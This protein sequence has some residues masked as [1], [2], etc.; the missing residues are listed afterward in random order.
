MARAVRR[1]D[2]SATAV[3]ADH[4]DSITGHDRVIGA[5]R[6]VRPE[7][8]AEAEIVDDQPDLG[9]LSLA[10][11]PIAVKENTAVTG[12]PTWNGSHEA[13]QPVADSDHEVVRRLR[14]AGA[15]V[16]G[17]TRMPELGLFATTDDA[18][19]VTRNPWRTDCTA[20]GSSGGS[21]A[22]VSAGLVPLAHGTDEMGSIRVPAACCGVV[23]LKPGRG[24]VPAGIGAND[25]Y[26]LAEHGLLG[27]TVADVAIGF[28]VLAGQTPQRLVPR[29]GLRIACST[30]SAM[31]GVTADQGARGALRDA[32]KLLVLAGHDTLTAAPPYPTS[33]ALCA[34][35][36]WMASGY[37]DAQ[38][39]GLDVRG[40]QQRTRRQIW[41]GR[42]AVRAGLVRAA[43]R[44]A[45][46]SMCQ[47]WFAAGRFDLLV[48]PAI[49]GPVPGAKDWA[50]RSW[51]ANILAGL[52]LAAYAAPWNVAGFPALVVPVGVRD[53]GLPASVQLVGP[54]GSEST[55]LAVA[56]Q[57]EMLAPWR[58]HA[59]GWPRWFT[60]RRR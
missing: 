27:A 8:L 60:R 54:P 35:A 37:L 51:T 31:T 4:L 20:G 13:R 9:N 58:R 32:A 3:I 6:L 36:T 38:A 10:G 28:A 59:P 7:A 25:C 18:T 52:R 2:T 39:S 55:L 33:A 21:A 19:G 50:R 34:V 15:V 30:E 11:V 5:F 12:L 57:M 45:Y 46:R 41:F 53:D 43:D 47:Q 29:E 56:G 24:V 48:T 40:L 16:V 42:H 49:P 44:Q 17:V 23:G 14:G 22:A 26:G 1:G